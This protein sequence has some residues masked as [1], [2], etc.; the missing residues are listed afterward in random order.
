[1][2]FDSV[3]QDGATHALKKRFKSKGIIRFITERGKEGEWL[4]FLLTFGLILQSA[5]AKCGS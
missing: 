1:M 2:Y 5:F 4:F 3:S